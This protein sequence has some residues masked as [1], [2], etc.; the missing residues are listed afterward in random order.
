[1]NSRIINVRIPSQNKTVSTPAFLSRMV[2]CLNHHKLCT[3]SIKFDGDEVSIV[4]N[5]YAK[6]IKWIGNIK[7]HTNENTYNL[8][9]NNTSIAV[10][11]P[12]FSESN[13]IATWK[14]DKS[15]AKAVD[16]TV[17]KLLRN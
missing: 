2:F 17:F 5:D 16:N 15:K 12:P 14:F 1:M 7:S 11:L 4:F 3:N 9:K 13:L 6:F 8:I 10:T